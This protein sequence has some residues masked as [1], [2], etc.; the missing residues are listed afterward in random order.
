MS[1]SIR[2]LSRAVLATLALSAS[3]GAAMAQNVQPSSSASKS[4]KPAPAAAPW[5]QVE[6]AWVRPMV[7]GQTATGGFM[8]LTAR[9]ALTL[10]GFSMARAGVPELHEM[11]MDGQVMRMR[12]IASLALPAGQAVVLRPGGHHLML[13][14]L[15]EPLKEGDVLSLTLKLRTTDGKAVTQTVSLPVKAHMM[16]PAADAATGASTPMHP[17]A[18]GHHHGMAH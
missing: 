5:V 12:A 4:A 1:P 8:V 10:E 16:M 3:L 7:P 9:Q 18:G 14:Q 13:T 6:S 17:G 11:T 2:L 15:Q